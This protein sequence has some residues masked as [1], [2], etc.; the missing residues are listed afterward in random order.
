MQK[1]KDQSIETNLQQHSDLTAKA[2]DAARQFDE[3]WRTLSG[4]R[5]IRSA[6]GPHRSSVLGVAPLKRAHSASGIEYFH[7]H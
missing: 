6:S 4:G 7:R 1:L 3:T 5:R 2:D